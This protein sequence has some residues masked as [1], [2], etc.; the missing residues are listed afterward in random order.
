MPSAFFTDAHCTKAL[1]SR[2][3]A[4]TN[5]PTMPLQLSIHGSTKS[6]VC[7]VHL[8]A[9]LIKSCGENSK[10]TLIAANIIALTNTINLKQTARTTVRSAVCPPSWPNP[11]HFNAFVCK[12][13]L[14]CMRNVKGVDMRMTHTQW[15]KEDSWDCAECPSRA[16]LHI[17]KIA[18]APFPLNLAHSQQ[19]SSR[20]S[21]SFALEREK[22][23][24]A[25]IFQARQG[26]W[27]TRRAYARSWFA[28]NLEGWRS[29][30]VCIAPDSYRVNSVDIIVVEGHELSDGGEHGLLQIEEG[31]D[32]DLHQTVR[33]LVTSH[34]TIYRLLSC[35]GLSKAG[36]EAKGQTLY[37]FTRELGH[38]RHTFCTA[39]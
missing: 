4:L 12:M 24:F 8:D 19:R 26:S 10:L 38:R 21:R 20:R 39:V 23:Q 30:E 36:R 32:Q 37:F 27:S 2:R 15:Y 18:P 14:N 34:R 25:I 31:R 13:R 35:Q 1:R 7:A 5:E 29:G 11:L 22:I 6:A 9:L 17:R 33:N 3:T 16:G 28:G